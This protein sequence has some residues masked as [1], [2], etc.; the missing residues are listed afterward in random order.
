SKYMMRLQ[1][2]R[3]D[4]P[5]A[6]SHIGHGAGRDR[7]I[8]GAACNGNSCQLFTCGVKDIKSISCRSPDLIYCGASCSYASGGQSIDGTTGLEGILYRASGSV[9]GTD[10]GITVAGRVDY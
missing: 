10:A 1:V 4:I 6:R 5:L 3:I 8:L 9:K 2:Y 7:E